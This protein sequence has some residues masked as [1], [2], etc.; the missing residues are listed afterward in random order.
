LEKLSVFV[1]RVVQAVPHYN[2]GLKTEAVS[3]FETF[4]PLY[5]S[6]TRHVPDD[7]IFINTSVKTPILYWNVTFKEIKKFNNAIILL[8]KF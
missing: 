6:T 1:F 7:W 8:Q 5:Q 3:I 4:V 2:I